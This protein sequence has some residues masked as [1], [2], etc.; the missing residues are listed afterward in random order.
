[1]TTG[2]QVGSTAPGVDLR[3]AFRA[4]FPSGRR[5]LWV[6]GRG[7]DRADGLVASRP[8]RTVQA[9]IDRSRAGDRIVVG[10]G[11]YGHTE[12]FDRHGTPDAWITVEAAAGTTPVI[13][14]S[15]SRASWDPTRG[16]NG[17][18]VQL[19]SH[20]A[21]FGL[22]IRG[23]Q[24][25][26]DPDPSGIA[27]FR[28]SRSVGIWACHVHDFPGGGVNCFHSAA[29]AVGA[30]V[31]PAGGW[32]AVDVSF[33]TIHATSRRSSY[34]TSGISFYGAQDLVATT[35]SRPYGYR[36]VG[37]YVY[38][39]VCTVPYRPGG[40]DFV[41]DGNGISVDSLA[42]ANSLAPG[43]APY[44]KRG[45]VEG[46]VVT[47]CGGRGVHVYNSR[48]V[49]VVGNT[50]VGNLRTASP[51]ITGS[52]EVAV[53]LDRPLASNG[54]V[55]AANVLAPLSSARAFDR[56][57][58]TV[59]ANTAVSGTD[60]VPPGNQSLRSLGLGAFVVRPTTAGLALGPEL[61][62]LALVVQT[63]VARRPGTT[64]W[65]ALGRGTRAT[66]ASVAV[67]AVRDLPR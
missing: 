36:A 29:A 1:V 35:A 18:D 40:F 63:L 3:A 10:A 34:N 37:N 65:A 44:L 55:V 30:T 56:V 12:F 60:A 47:A 67:G 61:G 5:S 19:S 50:L 26:A 62:S 33:C 2:S 4:E 48:N 31:L 38:D 13:N 32:D 6:S 42:V 53:S 41:T 27:V 11:T 64:G 14:V 22:E 9:A 20:V 52:T 25:S 17:L 46:N 43:L 39:V 57:A 8:L 23:D 28:G 51:A 45:L 58:Q 59:T 16:T 21:V 15:R 66:G 7:D 49:D 54:V 24:A